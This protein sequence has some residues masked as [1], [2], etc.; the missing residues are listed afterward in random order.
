MSLTTFVHSTTA[1]AEE[2]QSN[3]EFVGI[4]DLLPRGG[5]SLEP[6][7]EVY[8]LGSDSYKWNN[9]FCG[10]VDIVNSVSTVDNT[11]WV[12]IG[13]H[14]CQTNTATVEFTGLNGDEDEEYLIYAYG[15]DS[16]TIQMN[17]ITS[18]FTN[19]SQYIEWSN[20]VPNASRG[21]GLGA[22]NL[23]SANRRGFSRTLIK[24]KTGNDILV[25]SN[26]T[27]ENA[28]AITSR[29]SAVIYANNT[30]TV[31]TLKFGMKQTGTTI[32]IWSRQ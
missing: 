12:L 17:T 10:N 25:L 26:R 5:S 7:T 4:G 1:R 11:L 20:G 14:T 22:L 15:V 24:A 21:S 27:Q 16:V 3:F 2:V 32:K 13:E 29:N 9:L 18:F 28:S 8:D 31:T 30:T 19:G 23:I 6:T